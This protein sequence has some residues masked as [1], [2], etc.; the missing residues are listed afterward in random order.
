MNRQVGS[1]VR[2]EI[3]IDGQAIAP[4]DGALVTAVSIFLASPPHGRCEIRF[5][6]AGLR[7]TPP[8][9]GRPLEISLHSF[10]SAA[11]VSFSGEIDDVRSRGGADDELLVI[12]AVRVQGQDDPA[13]DPE[14]T[15]PPAIEARRGGNA[16]VWDLSFNVEQGEP[17]LPGGPDHRGSVTIV[18]DPAALVGGT[19]DVR[20]RPG[21]SGLY[22]IEA[23]EH[24]WGVL[25]YE[26]QLAIVRLA[27]MPEA[28][29]P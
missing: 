2:F 3:K 1:M 14:T 27:E 22:R 26:T 28:N 19:C 16:L 10:G 29:G 25:G 17:S 23:A 8:R 21:I 4:E 12:T 5:R 9:T 7:L 24:R 11:S 20:I 6:D 15:R 18:G 13:E